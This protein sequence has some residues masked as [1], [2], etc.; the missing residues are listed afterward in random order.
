MRAIC[1]DATNST[2]LQEGMQYFVFPHGPDAFYV[3]KFNSEES[4]TGAY[5]RDRFEVVEEV[6]KIQEKDIAARDN[7]KKTFHWEQ[8]DLFDFLPDDLEENQQVIKIIIPEDIIHPLDC[9]HSLKSKAFRN[10]QLRWS[11]YVRAIQDYHD[12]SWFEATDKLLEH[13]K[14]KLPIVMA[15][16]PEGK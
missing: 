2:V 13:Q 4:H 14:S 10:V 12:C 6:E 1:K 3:S 15:R 11:S 8:M 5:Q 9:I 16:D 7:S